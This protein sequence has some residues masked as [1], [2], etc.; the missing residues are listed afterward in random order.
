MHWRRS[1]LP[2]WYGVLGLA[3]RTGEYDKITT[4]SS[5]LFDDGIDITYNEVPAA[6]CGN[7]TSYSGYV[8]F[9]PNSMKNVEHDYPIHTFFWYFES[10]TDAQN[11]PLIIWMNGGPGASSMFGLFAENGP[12]FINSDLEQELRNS[13]WN[14]FYNILYVDQ[15]VQTGFSYDIP[16][17][18]FLD[19]ETGNIIPEDP[20]QNLH[21]N[22]TFIPGNFSSQNVNWTA[23]T[24]ENAARHFWNFL[25]AWSQDFKE[26]NSSDNSISIWTESYG[27]R[28]GP[29]FAAFIE[30]Q[31]LQIRHGFLPGAK[32][33]NITT[34]GII[35]GCVDL[36]IQETSAPEFAYDRNTYGIP[37]TIGEEYEAALVAYSQKGGCLD[38]IDKCLYLGKRFDP[39]MYGNVTEVNDACEDASD[40]CQ[41][42]VE[43]PYIFRK[44]WA[45]YD[46]AHCYLDAFPGNEFLYYLSSEEILKAIGVPVNYTDISNT[47]G[48]A[49]NLTGDY[50]RRD[51][52]GYLEDIA[53]LL[54]SGIQVAMIYGD[55]DFACNW[56][57]GERVSLAVE[58]SQSEKFSLAG[59]TNITIDGSDPG[60]QVRQHGMFSFSR[61]YQSGHMVPSYQPEVTL[62][63]LRRVMEQRDV[64]TGN[65]PISDDYSTDGTFESTVSL[66]AP[67]PPSMTC[68]LRG[69]PS[70][71]AQNQIDAVKD[72]SATI[73]NGVIRNPPPPE[74]T[75][76]KLPTSSDSMNELR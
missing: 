17:P 69:M 37:G 71:C 36:L 4:I 14:Q 52:R 9:P 12:C 48:K 25:Q 23:N 19:L 31:N 66:T 42:E 2:F 21:E 41:N 53:I 65:I 70:T 30:E 8:N 3:H 38:K 59:Y 16:T 61:I 60:G 27:G 47:V 1:I 58:Y 51:P 39:A 22:N 40:F 18:G 49:F 55:R 13:S 73:E 76:P 72:G 11:A 43:G 35:N 46:I 33:L 68:Y 75:C 6:I 56:V 45:F 28:Y 7:A 15:P 62:S 10:Q 5:D 32:H 67:Q 44:Q 29:G 54:D 50:S 57:G 74:G 63:I 34:L 20:D 24:T 64:A 26:Y